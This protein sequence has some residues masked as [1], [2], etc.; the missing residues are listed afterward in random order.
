MSII[1][2]VSNYSVLN[3][4]LASTRACRQ[5]EEKIFSFSFIMTPANNLVVKFKKK[6]FSTIVTIKGLDRATKISF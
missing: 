5:Y 4:K 6:V 1:E 3:Q 2:E